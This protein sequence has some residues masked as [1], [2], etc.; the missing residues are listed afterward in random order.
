MKETIHAT[1]HVCQSEGCLKMPARRIFRR[2]EEVQSL[3]D[4]YHFF[5]GECGGE[6][7]EGME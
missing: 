6:G 3:F 7:L 4:V 5:Q 1:N 2:K